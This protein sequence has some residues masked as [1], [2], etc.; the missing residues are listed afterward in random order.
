MAMRIG[1]VVPL[2]A[3]LAACQSAQV[4][5]TGSLSSYKD[6]VASDGMV[7][8]TKY[9]VDAASTKN[10]KTVHVIPTTFASNA[11][12]DKLGDPQKKLVATAIDRSLC[13]ALSAQFDI[14]PISKPADMAVRSVISKVKS[15]NAV[16]AGVS[17]VTSAVAPVPVP[18][19]PIGLGSLAVEAEAFDARGK[20]IAGLTWARGANI[21]TNGSRASTAADAF[22][23]A[24]DFSGDF[25]ALLE[26]SGD[27]MKSDFELPSMKNVKNSVAYAVTGKPSDPDCAVFGKGSGLGGIAGG[28]LGL[29]PE[30]SEKKN[31]SAPIA[32]GSSGGAKKG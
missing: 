32:S 8:K 25:S 4:M 3:G 5:E 9:R 22:E 20:Q 15:T 28:A 1:A 24:G 27:P 26:K 13:E 23:L 16:V 19:I 12:L 17:T 30:W 29:P 11:D 21:L 10:V 18:R 6:F 14:V 7:T 31:E 2:L